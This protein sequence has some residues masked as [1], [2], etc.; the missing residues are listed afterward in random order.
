[1]FDEFGVEKAEFEVDC[2]PL[3]PSTM[4]LIIDMVDF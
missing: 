1:L 4:S 3:N 2:E